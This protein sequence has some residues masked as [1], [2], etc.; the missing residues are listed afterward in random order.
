MQINTQN[1]ISFIK[2]NYIGIIAV[3]VLLYVIYKVYYMLSEKK[4]P[5]ELG[6]SN[7]ESKDYAPVPYNTVKTAN[8]NISE[9]TCK[10]GTKVPAAYTGNAM[11]LLTNLQVL[12]EALGLPIHINSGYRSPAHNKKVGG[13]A[14]SMHMRGMAADITV[15]GKSPAQVHGKI[16]ELIA[17]GK[18]QNGGLKQY[19]TFV[20]YDVAKPRTW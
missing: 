12:R 1:I 13:A 18:M 7:A 17:A 11:R 5:G 10:D 3:A 15:L 4:E 8:F 16:K 2:K 19:P 9:M 6:S 14:N 20:H